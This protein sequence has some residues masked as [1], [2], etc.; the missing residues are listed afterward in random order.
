MSERI[1]TIGHSNQTLEAFLSLLSAYGIGVIADVRSTPVSR[2]SPQFDQKTIALALPRSGFKY[3]Y[4][5]AELGGRP[6]TSGFYDTKR[7][8]LYDQVAQS[9]TF[10]QGIQRLMKGAES[11]VVA[12]MCSEE[13]PSFCHRRLLIGRVL[14]ESGVEIAHIRGDGSLQTEAEL[15]RLEQA[16]ERQPQLMLFET[17]GEYK[18]WRSAKPIPSASPR[19]ERRSSLKR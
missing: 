17:R 4:M 10:G 8:V 6:S 15:A 14:T 3:V 13:D 11:Y 1:L 19:G 7:R 5:G 12:V 18:A 16:T 9:P 2:Y